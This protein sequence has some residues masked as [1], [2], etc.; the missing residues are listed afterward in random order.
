MNAVDE[1]KFQHLLTQIQTDLGTDTSRWYVPEGYPSTA[2]AILDSIYSTG[3]R[4]NGVVNLRS[5]YSAL[6][7]EDG[8][9]ASKDDARDLA[10]AIRLCGGPEA[11]A[12][13]TRNRWR[14]S[15]RTSAPRK[16]EAA[17]RAAELLMDLD[18]PTR[19]AVRSAMHDR[20]AREGSDLAKG[21]YAIPGQRSGLTYTYFLM[22]LGLPGV[23]AD[24]MIRRYVTRAVGSS[25]IVDAKSASRL[26]EKV[27]DE[28]NADY[29]TLDH[30]IWRFESGRGYLR[31]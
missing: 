8:A 6:R 30:T 20:D 11:F 23:K 4:Y 22:L 12:Q 2:L 10:G 5:R 18:M 27:A 21:W 19:D 3:N 29:S 25:R 26:V 28:I 16:A 14:T 9:D 17:L 24:R 13:A 15:S 31:N 7:E 1:A